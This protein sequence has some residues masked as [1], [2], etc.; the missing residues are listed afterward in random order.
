MCWLGAPRAGREPNTKTSSSCRRST[1]YMTI[2]TTFPI[3]KDR[4]GWPLK[5]DV[6]H[7]EDWPVAQPCLL[8]GAEAYGTQPWFETWK[9]LDHDPKVEEVIRNGEPLRLNEGGTDLIV[10]RADVFERLKDWL[11]DSPWTDEEMDLLAAED[12]DSLGW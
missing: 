6:M 11:E 12:A 4:R 1:D 9:R 8:F 7:W 2:T 5:P 3:H 10:L